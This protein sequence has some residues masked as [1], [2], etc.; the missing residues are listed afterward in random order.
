[1]SIMTYP[2]MATCTLHHEG[3]MCYF[4]HATCRLT[5]PTALIAQVAAH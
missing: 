5:Y 2:F 4:F 3:H 1:M